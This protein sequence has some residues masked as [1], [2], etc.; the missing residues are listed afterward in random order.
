MK[1]EFVLKPHEERHLRMA[2]GVV[3]SVKSFNPN[4]ENPVKPLK[5]SILIDERKDTQ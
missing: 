2:N 3:I 5:I 1:K 4:N